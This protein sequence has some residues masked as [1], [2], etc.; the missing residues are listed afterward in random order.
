MGNP[1]L[2]E[3]N[4]S[5]Y[6]KLEE[7]IN[8]ITK[9]LVFGSERYATFEG[10]EITAGRILPVFISEIKKINY[11]PHDSFQE[12][13]DLLMNYTNDGN[14]NISSFGFIMA[15]KLYSLR[16]RLLPDEPPE[17]YLLDLLHLFE[18]TA[19][20]T[21]ENIL[22]RGPAS[23]ALVSV[24]RKRHER[25]LN[26]WHLDPDWTVLQKNIQD[27]EKSKESQTIKT[28]DLDSYVKKNLNFI[29][30]IVGPPPSDE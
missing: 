19:Y 28:R 27:G 30:D 3:L 6:D 7:T 17:G 21:E 18:E 23:N 25:N 4:K 10:G 16:G 12:I 1:D 13:Y 5:R 24:E 11:E 2:I 8:Y 15:T 14:E 22:L 29:E 20:D 26:Q 9:N